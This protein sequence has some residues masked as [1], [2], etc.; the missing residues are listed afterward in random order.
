MGRSTRRGF[1]LVELLVV[2]GIIGLLMGLLLPAIQTA[3]NAAQSVSCQTRLHQMGIML[4]QF[5]DRQG[6]NGA[7]PDVVVM[8]SLTPGRPSLAD[9]L[10]PFSGGDKNVFACP[11]DTV[12]FPREGISYE[13]QQLTFG[14][15]LRKE[16]LTSRRGKPLAAETVPILFD[17][18]AFHGAKGMAGDRNVLYADWH[19]EKF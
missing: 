3:R 17:F 2:I 5:L 1:T 9:T 12:Y 7:Y 6:P 14:G 18:D 16:A 4:Q 15:K 19:V 11:Q 13:Y 10:A 8:P